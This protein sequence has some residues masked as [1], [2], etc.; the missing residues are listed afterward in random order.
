MKPKNPESQMPRMRHPSLS[1]EEERIGSHVV[2]ASYAVHSELGPGLLE[3]VYETCL[4]FELR[5]RGL[6]LRRQVPVKVRYRG[7]EL[8]DGMRLDLLVEN[9]VIVELKAVASDNDLYRAQVLTYMKLTQK[10]LGY[11]INFNVPKI[12]D[13]ISRMILRF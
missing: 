5:D 10:R 2:D 8:D 3:S 12:G 13:G 1:D 7:L 4:E 9:L 11:L 6:D